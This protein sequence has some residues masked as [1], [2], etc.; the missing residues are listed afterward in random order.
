VNQPPERFLAFPNLTLAHGET[1][2]PIP[3]A[4]HLGGP[5]VPGTAARITV[6]LAGQTR[7]I[8][9]ALHDAETPLTVANFV[10]YVNAGRYAANFFHRSVP[11]LMIY[12]AMDQSRAPGCVAT[13][14]VG[15]RLEAGPVCR[16][17]D[18]SRQGA[19]AAGL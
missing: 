1:S 15:P 14:F 11:D 12:T 13:S 2:A 3:L 17:E 7:T 8:D 5:D 4:D 10:A 19:P 6:R 9:L 18:G 16:D